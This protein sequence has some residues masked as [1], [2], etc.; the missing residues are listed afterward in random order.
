MRRVLDREVS[1][2]CS[3]TLDFRSLS[4]KVKSDG[5]ALL[6]CGGESDFGAGSY[7]RGSMEGHLRKSAWGAT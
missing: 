3:G 5:S 7:A 2:V 1:M 4:M 6:E